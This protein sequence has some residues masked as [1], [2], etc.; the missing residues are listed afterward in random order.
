VAWEGEGSWRNGAFS[1]MTG[2]MTRKNK[3]GVIV[4]PDQALDR[5]SVLK[6]A[7]AWGSEYMLKEDKLGSLEVG[8]LA[9]FLVLNQDYFTIPIEQIDV[10]Y[11]LMTVVG[12]QVRYLRDE[13]AS[14]VGEAPVGAQ[15]RYTFEEGGN[16]SPLTTLS[17]LH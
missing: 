12:G 7:T 10:T 14:E 17:H 11:P 3:Q 5:V 8:K 6:M 16:H 9:D 2:F 13:F 15:L 4:G 1:L